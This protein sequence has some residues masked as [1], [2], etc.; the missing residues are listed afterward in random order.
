MPQT[1]LALWSLKGRDTPDNL[2]FTVNVHKRF[3]KSHYYTL[4]YFNLLYLKN[5]TLD[6]Y[7][8]PA[9]SKIFE[10]ELGKQLSAYFENILSK[11]QCGF[12][13]SFST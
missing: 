8:P 9:I 13:K 12:R 4:L 6:Y 5:Y 1:R 7:R 3:I 2:D 10:K 11:F